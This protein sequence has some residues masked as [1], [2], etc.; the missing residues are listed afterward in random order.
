M[1]LPLKT[2]NADAIPTEAETYWQINMPL[3]FGAKGIEYFT[4]VQPYYYSYDDESPEAVDCSNVV[5][6]NANGVDCG[7]SHD[8]DRNCLIG[9]DG[10]PT[11]HYA[12][13]KKAN[14]QIAAVDE[15]LMKAS[16]KG[17][18]AKG[19]YAESSTSGVSGIISSTDILDKVE[20]TGD[21]GAVVGCFD[22]RDTET[23]Y[24]VNYDVTTTQDITLGFS[25]EQTY[26]VIM[27][28][29]ESVGAGSEITLNIAPGEGALIVLDEEKTTKY[30]YFEDI[31]PYR[32]A[33]GVS[34]KAP[35][36]EGYLFAGWFKYASDTATAISK[37]KVTGSA[38]ARFVDEDLL[39]VKGQVRYGDLNNI[40]RM[41]LRFITTVDSLRYSTMGFE[42]AYNDKF[43]QAESTGVYL[44]LNAW[45]EDNQQYREYKPSDLCVSAQYFK[46]YTL[47]NISIDNFNTPIEARAY[48]VTLDGTKVYGESSVKRVYQG[49]ESLTSPE[50]YQYNE[51][52][53]SN[54]NMVGDVY[55][56]DYHYGCM[57]G[58]VTDL[59]GKYL[60]MDVI[61]P[62]NGGNPAADGTR[63]GVAT[64]DQA[65]WQGIRIFIQEGRLCIKDANR[66]YDL[67]QYGIKAG[68][69]FNL[70]LSM[71]DIDTTNN[72]CTLGIWINNMF[73][74]CAFDTYTD[75]E[76][77]NALAVAVVSPCGSVMIG[78]PTK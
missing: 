15:V 68:E 57:N 69:R 30:V 43:K 70:K 31:S 24:V 64:T 9:A 73:A 10:Q 38:Y 28:G 61:L 77:G 2:V 45:E 35:E 36:L 19:T 25:S 34:H 21:Y 29:K 42:L 37:T 50:A 8:F 20:V 78:R 75:R 13:A 72:A 41:S 3:A 11:T 65:G 39:N 63:I 56:K 76:L 40:D 32:A 54:F 60:N 52:T 23:Y 6:C 59:E 46:A 7:H 74:G 51:V 17:V 22:Y 14:K 71:K 49:I 67:E 1:Q 12:Y 27:D 58:T 48:W 26:S 66:S 16:S 53:I 4:L 47:N 5:R 55:S 18:I 44:K 62:D 33:D